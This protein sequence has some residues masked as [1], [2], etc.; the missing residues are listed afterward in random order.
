MK[1]RGEDMHQLARE[2]WP[3]PRSI[4]GHG[5]KD[6]LA[7]L[8]REL[9]NLDI[10][11]VPTGT[12][13]LDW[14]VPQEW[15]VNDA[16]IKTPDG[17]K[18]CHFKAHNLHL[19]NSSVGIHE[20]MSLE[21]LDKHL[22][23][24]P[25]QPDAIPYRTSYFAPRW[26]F[27][28]EHSVR[29][30]LAEGQYEVFIDAGHKPGHLT[31]GELF[32]KGDR[33]EEIFISTYICHP[34][35]ANNELSGPVV[36]TEL[37]KWLLSLPERRY[38]YRIVFAPETIGAIAYIAS[39]LEAL[40]ARVVAGF[41]L[42]C[43]G[44]ERTYSFMPS[45][46]GNTISD[47]VAQHV[48]KHLCGTFDAYG[49]RD[50][51]SDERQYCAPGV[52]LPVVSIMRS[53]Y[54]TFPEYHTSLD[55]LDNLVTPEGL[56]GGFEANRLA[57][58][59]LERNVTPVTN[60]IGEP[61]MSKRNLRPTLGGDNHNTGDFKLISDL[62]SMSDGS[63]SLLDIAEFLDVPAWELYAPLDRLIDTGLISL[64]QRS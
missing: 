23:S 63:R 9:G 35:M 12:D 5:V 14:T 17:R 44:D 56:A 53:K 13:I 24:L 41:N 42:T 21:E 22:Y 36:T 30:T 4:T 47:A 50:R 64:A 16:W 43:V 19:L 7:I 34:S 59:I 57:L 20:H 31:Y 58:E 54:G 1:N 38:S 51:G 62:I 37:A 48:L 10:V 29:E 27:C 25:D 2:L 3:L 6:T 33:E 32:I 55:D 61:F 11:N 45:R 52:D 49:W 26:G 28:I 46:A 8:R 39:N 60:V 40:K 15:W 18:I